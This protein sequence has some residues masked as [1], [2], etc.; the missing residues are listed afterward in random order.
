MGR[1]KSD[2]R[3]VPEGRRKTVEIA[4]AQRGGKA[5]TASQSAEQLELFHATAD[6]PKGDVDGADIGLPVSA[7]LAVPKSW[8]TTS[9]RLPAMTIRLGVKPATAWR[10]LY[11]EHRSWWALSHCSA[12][13]RGLRNA[14]FAERGLVSILD[15]WKE[16]THKHGRAPVQLSLALG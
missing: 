13:D 14:Y 12:V 1:E 11:R 5:T 7:T 4:A 16:K 2:G 10:S 8:N 15:E 3:M 6:S 9:K